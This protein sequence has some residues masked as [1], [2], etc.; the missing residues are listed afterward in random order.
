MSNKKIQFRL[1]EL[2]AEK[3]RKTGENVTYAIITEETGIS[4]NSLS[5]MAQQKTKMIGLSTIERLLVFF[6]CDIDDLIVYE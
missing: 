6:D 2:I 3:E 4:P 5:N 1:R